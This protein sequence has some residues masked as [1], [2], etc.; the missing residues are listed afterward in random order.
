[1][2]HIVQTALTTFQMNFSSLM[3]N[4]ILMI[5]V[6]EGTVWQ[7]TLEREGV[8][9][10]L[11][12]KGSGAV[13]W[14]SSSRAIVW[15]LLACATRWGLEGLKYGL[16][17]AGRKKHHNI[18]FLSHLWFSIFVSIILLK[19]VETLFSKVDELNI[20]Y[21]W[22]FFGFVGYFG[23]LFNICIC[24]LI[25]TIG[26]VMGILRTFVKYYF[27][28]SIFYIKIFLQLHKQELNSCLRLLS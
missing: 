11:S 3:L 16:V 7:I 8:V 22:Y 12:W 26:L 14:L 28:P 1:M 25:I 27:F 5:F 24:N 17:A 13:L 20:R 23:W 21:Y 10:V 2:K 15:L 9:E 18:A 4:L 19:E 6:T